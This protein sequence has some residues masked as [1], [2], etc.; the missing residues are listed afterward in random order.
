MLKCYKTVVIKISRTRLHTEVCYKGY[1]ETFVHVLRLIFN[2]SL[3][4]NT[5]PDLWKQAAV[6]PVLKKGN[7]SCVGN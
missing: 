5:F 7:I 6:V 3:S 4:Q 2:L 1:S